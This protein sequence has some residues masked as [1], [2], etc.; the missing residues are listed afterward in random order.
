MSE[1]I[2]E[3]ISEPSGVKVPDSTFDLLLTDGSSQCACEGPCVL[4]NLSLSNE[5]PFTIYLYVYDGEVLQFR[6]PIGPLG[7]RDISF[8]NGVTFTNSLRLVASLK[9][10]TLTPPNSTWVCAMGAYVAK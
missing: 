4:Y 9:Y 8:T 5:E 2:S 1:P 6:L 10:T 7:S 3:P